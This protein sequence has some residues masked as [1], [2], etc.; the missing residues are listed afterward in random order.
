L[1]FFHLICL[2]THHTANR[3]I[4]LSM[5]ERVSI[6]A[7]TLL[8]ASLLPLS[9][10]DAYEYGVD[11]SFPI[12]HTFSGEDADVSSTGRVFN[13]DKIQLYADYV[14]GCKEMY[15]PMNKG[16]DCIFNEEERLRLNLNQPRAMTNHTDVGFAKVRLSDDVW[17]MLR[18]FWEQIMEE[19]GIE[20]LEEEYWPEAN[21]YTNHW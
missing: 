6:P 14:S 8:L 12:H 4:M 7:N 11:V 3:G 20:Q 5:L 10:V 9:T 17:R 16:G 18:E 1:F 13:G 15:S 21:T 19:G 2:T